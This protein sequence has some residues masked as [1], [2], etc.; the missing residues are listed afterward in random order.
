VLQRATVGTSRLY[1]GLDGGWWGI[2]A[3]LAGSSS[4]ISQPPDH[5]CP[6]CPLP[7]GQFAVCLMT[8]EKTLIAD[9]SD[10]GGPGRNG[11]AEAEELKFINTGLEA[12][13]RTDHS[14]PLQSEALRTEGQSKVVFWTMRG[15]SWPGRAGNGDVTGGAMRELRPEVSATEQGSF[16]KFMKKE[17]STKV[18]LSSLQQGSKPGLSPKKRCRTEVPSLAS[19]VGIGPDKRPP[20]FHLQEG[21]LLGMKQLLEG[22]QLRPRV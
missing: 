4:G 10:E 5:V 2:L 21:D 13:H 17:V 16:M 6:L 18:C 1:P 3:A 11:H 22:A 7:L 14:A 8:N 20:T 9:A 15:D 19:T 12:E